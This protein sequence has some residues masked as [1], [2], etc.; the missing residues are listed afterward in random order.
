MTF[1]TLA[2]LVLVLGL[3]QARRT[4]GLDRR[5][6][7]VFVD[8]PDTSCYWTTSGRD[9]V[10]RIRARPQG[11]RPARTGHSVETGSGGSSTRCR[12]SAC[13]SWRSGTHDDHDDRAKRL[14]GQAPPALATVLTIGLLD[15]VAARGLRPAWRSRGSGRHHDASLHAGRRPWHTGS[16]VCAATR[17]STRKSPRA[18]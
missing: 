18:N 2:A 8:C 14:G 5:P 4:A 12:S 10:R 13:S 9:H 11:C 3:Q 1:T 15:F 7:Q 16:S 6:P 17:N